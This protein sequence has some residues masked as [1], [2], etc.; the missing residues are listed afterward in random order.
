VSADAISFGSILRKDSATVLLGEDAT[1]EIFVFSRNVE[2][3]SFRIQLDEYPN[4]FTISHPVSFDMGSEFLKDEYVMIDGEYVKGRVVV[5][6]VDVPSHSK[7]GEYDIR[8]KIVPTSQ[9][10]DDSFIDVTGEQS[11]LLNVN[12]IEEKKSQEIGEIAVVG[13]GSIRE[14]EDSVEGVNEDLVTSEK[15]LES[16]DTNVIP[17]ETLTNERPDSGTNP[18]TGLFTAV[19]EGSRGYVVLF[20]VVLV[21]LGLSYLI[22]KNYGNN[23]IDVAGV[24]EYPESDQTTNKPVVPAQNNGLKN[25]EI[26]K[27]DTL[28]E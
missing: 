15:D 24:I 13:G 28:G 17:D 12:V 27:N 16:D 10:G 26:D 1:F 8:L 6:T 9:N 21:I 23:K 19:T 5:V 7:T 22:Y 4:E 20:F 14:S 2:S 11:H 3:Q 25:V 18:I